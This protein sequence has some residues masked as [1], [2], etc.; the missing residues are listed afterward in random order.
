[1]LFV[2]YDDVVYIIS[3]TFSVEESLLLSWS[4]STR[5][6]LTFYTISSIHQRLVFTFHYLNDFSKQDVIFCIDYF[7]SYNLWPFIKDWSLWF[8]LFRGSA[9]YAIPLH[10][11]LGC[12]H[13]YLTFNICQL[14]YK[15]IL[16]LGLHQHAGL[17]CSCFVSCFHFFL[18]VIY[19]LIKSGQ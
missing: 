19:K 14:I 9:I 3:V 12:F 4:Q 7:L 2:L 18:F 13:I 17:V 1:M 10:K 8:A 11:L 6:L 16:C 15:V 5:L